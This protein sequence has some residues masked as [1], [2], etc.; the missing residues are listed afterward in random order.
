MQFCYDKDK[1]KYDKD[2][3][4]HREDNDK[5][6]YAWKNNVGYDASIAKNGDVGNNWQWFGLVQEYQ[7]QTI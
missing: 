7:T 5:G 1:A 6:F 2:K 3:G 4:K